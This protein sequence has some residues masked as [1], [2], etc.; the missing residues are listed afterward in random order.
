MKISLKTEYALKATLDLSL[1]ARRG[2]P[3]RKIRDIAEA[4]DIPEKYLVQILLELNRAGILNSVRGVNGGYRLA[5]GPES[6]TVYDVVAAVEGRD[7]IIECLLPEGSEK[8]CAT[9][10]MCPFKGVWERVSEQMRETLS[11]VRFADIAKRVENDTSMYY[12]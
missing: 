8:K 4:Q 7:P 10:R 2:N 1:A 6:I 9:G 3:L 11:E 12:I 5:R